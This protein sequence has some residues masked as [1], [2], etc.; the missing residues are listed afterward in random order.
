MSFDGEYKLESPVFDTIPDAWNYGNELGSKW[1]FYPFHFVVTESGKTIRD[2]PNQLEE[3]D[4]IS[5]KKVAS[6]FNNTNK[7]LDDKKLNAD[8]DQFISYLVD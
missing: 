8:C 1:Y 7:M 5:V 4:N 6:I 2:T 3:F